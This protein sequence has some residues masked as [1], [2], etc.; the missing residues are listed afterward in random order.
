MSAVFQFVITKLA[1]SNA[2]LSLSDSLFEHKMNPHICC[3]SNYHMLVLHFHSHK[4]DATLSNGT[5]MPKG[6]E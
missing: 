6:A 1:E 3:E 2:I 4:T 5:T